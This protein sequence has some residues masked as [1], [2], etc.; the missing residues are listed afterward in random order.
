VTPVLH[1]RIS[2]PI[3]LPTRLLRC[4][5]TMIDDELL[6]MPSAHRSAV[7]AHMPHSRRWR[8]GSELQFTPVARGWPGRGLDGAVRRGVSFHGQDVD[9]GGRAPW[10]VSSDRE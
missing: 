3:R 4:L 9:V 6:P 10:G 8:G 1:L 7:C 2:E 5:Q